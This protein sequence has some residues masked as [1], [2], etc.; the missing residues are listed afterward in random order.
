MLQIVWVLLV[1]TTVYF[2]LAEMILII[3]IGSI[4]FV[5]LL[6]FSQPHPGRIK[7]TTEGIY[8]DD[9]YFKLDQVR[10]IEAWDITSK[11][12]HPT[13]IG[14]EL[15]LEK[16]NLLY[17]FKE[18]P[19]HTSCDEV[20]YPN[21]LLNFI[22]EIKTKYPQLQNPDINP[23]E[24]KMKS[25][26]FVLYAFLSVIYSILLFFF[27]L[28]GLKWSDKEIEFKNSL[29]QLAVFLASA[30]TYCLHSKLI[31]S[32]SASRH[33]WSKQV[34]EKVIIRKK[35][36]AFGCALIFFLS[37]LRG[38]HFIDRNYGLRNDKAVSLKLISLSYR[39]LKGCHGKLVF[40]GSGWSE[41]PIHVACRDLHSY[42]VGQRYLLNMKFGSLGGVMLMPPRGVF[43]R[44]SKKVQDYNDINEF[45]NDVDNLHR[46]RSNTF[47]YFSKSDKANVIIKNISAWKLECEKGKGDYCRLL[48]YYN[49]LEG[50][51]DQSTLMFLDGCRKNDSHSC[52][53]VIL[54]SNDEIK[55]KE[56]KAILSESCIRNRNESCSTL[57]YAAWA[58][59]KLSLSDPV[60]DALESYCDNRDKPA[61]LL[62]RK[63]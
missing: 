62:L 40:A 41:L 63:F 48:G 44:N 16:D 39:F 60:M 49:E 35:L 58:K 43:E 51:K 28:D 22:S 23:F 42:E 1:A 26:R 61:C 13:K 30:L 45:L 6:G 7:L 33:K 24:E 36:A 4:I 57:L 9:L 38:L 50:Q 29:L 5:F 55:L 19:I 14:I 27:I 10:K 34:F 18:N 12:Q 11:V 25:V 32:L 2:Q 15:I 3:Y 46:I 20:D 8:A 53:A 31:I 37:A 17:H 54:T 47:E 52:F 59:K 21:T 56:V